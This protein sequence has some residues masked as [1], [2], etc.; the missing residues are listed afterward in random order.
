ETGA[1]A[2]A[3]IRI[4]KLE[5]A[6]AETAGEILRSIIELRG[7]TVGT[8]GGARAAGTAT[9]QEE[10]AS[11]IMLIWNR[12]HPELGVETLRAMRT[13]ITVIDNV[14]TN[15]LIVLAPPDSM[16]LIESL[17]AAI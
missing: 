1:L 7:G 13:G 2:G 10:A 12:L 11:Q 4:F 14:R 8:T 16:P 5:Q 17:V 3:A 15:E 9:A 6:D